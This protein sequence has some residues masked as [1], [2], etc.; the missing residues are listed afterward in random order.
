[1]TISK[2]NHVAVNSPIKIQGR[3]I[4]IIQWLSN[5]IDWYGSNGSE[6]NGRWIEPFMGSCNVGLAFCVPN[7]A[8]M[9]NRDRVWQ[10][11]G[12]H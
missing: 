12:M 9:G 7:K 10:N 11:R 8:L 1:M 5:N 3:K 6:K 4:K 2:S